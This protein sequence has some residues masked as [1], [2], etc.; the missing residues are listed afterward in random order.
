MYT[1][2]HL[3]FLVDSYYFNTFQTLDSM[4]NWTWWWRKW[5][6]IHLLNHSANTSQ[7]NDMSSHPVGTLWHLPLTS[8]LI[9][10]HTHH[11]PCVM[12]RTFPS[13]LQNT[14]ILSERL[15]RNMFE[16]KTWCC[17][18][19]FWIWKT[20][21]Y[22]TICDVSIRHE[23]SYL[24]HTHTHTHTHSLVYFLLVWFVFY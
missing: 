21:N 9:H 3:L 14:H 17:S 15:S 5:V 8:P 12:I 13:L 1:H 10:Y 16:I 11:H 22:W 6:W 7:W 2:S 20:C 19:Y 4:T 23:G 18:N 24:T